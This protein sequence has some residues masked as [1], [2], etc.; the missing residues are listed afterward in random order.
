MNRIE[1]VL[2][3]VRKSVRRPQAYSVEEVQQLL[4]HGFTSPKYRTFFMTLYGGG[5]RLN[6]GCH[7]QVKDIDSK[8]MLIRIEQGK[9]RKDRY[10]LLPQRLLEELRAYCRIYHPDSWLFPAQTT[11]ERPLNDRS[12]QKAFKLALERARLP[13]KGGPHSL[14]HSFA[15]HLIEAGVP[16]HVV[17]RLMGHTSMTTTAGYLH[18][19]QPTLEKVVNPLDQMSWANALAF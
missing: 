14:R 7:L 9:G 18:I 6:E 11:P 12:V 3:H 1:W 17:K 10:T 15:T 8:R 16:L 13:R 19:S 5:L 4:E 2:P